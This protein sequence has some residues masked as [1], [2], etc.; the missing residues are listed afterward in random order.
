MAF[1]STVSL[2]NST[3]L[4]I[5]VSISSYYKWLFKGIFWHV[6]SKTGA[7]SSIK[8]NGKPVMILESLIE[9]TYRI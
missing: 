8:K 6:L 7:H 2:S 4:A 1:V 9:N 3:G 5:A